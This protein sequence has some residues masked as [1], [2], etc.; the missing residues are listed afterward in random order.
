MNY[1]IDPVNGN[2]YDIFSLEGKN[3]L[4]NYIKVFQTG[5][6]FI[7]PICRE[8]LNGQDELLKHHPL[9]VKRNILVDTLK[10]NGYTTFARKGHLTNLTQDPRPVEDLLK[11]IDNIV[12]NSNMYNRY[13][14]PIFPHAS[15]LIEPM[16]NLIQDIVQKFNINTDDKNIEVDKALRDW[17][18]ALQDFCGEEEENKGEQ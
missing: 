6:G 9:C 10:K 15:S 1:I 16:N 7:C 14:Y 8:D 5:G 3:L 13:K 2:N 12:F 11:D 4:K 18:Y 17:I